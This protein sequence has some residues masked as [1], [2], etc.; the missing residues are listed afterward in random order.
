MLYRALFCN[1]LIVTAMTV[2]LFLKL[3]SAIDTVLYV[4]L[5]IALA[6]GYGILAVAVIRHRKELEAR[7]MM[8]L[9][10]IYNSTAVLKICQAIMLY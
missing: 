10:V 7:A 9:M 8:I 5:N 2:A 1:G 3:H 6:I 4:C